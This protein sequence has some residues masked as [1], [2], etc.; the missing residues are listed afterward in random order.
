[1]PT[2]SRGSLSFLG[3]HA[4]TMIRLRRVALAACFLA[5]PFVF[6]ESGCASRGPDL[7]ARMASAK[8]IYE[9]VGYTAFGAPAMGTT[10]EGTDGKVPLPLKEGCYQIVTFPGDGLK[11]IE[12]SL[13]D[14]AGKP[15]GEVKKQEGSVSIKHCVTEAATYNLVVKSTGGSGSFVA[16][17]YASS[18]KSASKGPDEPAGPTDCTGDDC[19]EPMI[20]DGSGD[21]CSG[22]IELAAGASIKGNNGGKGFAQRASCA[23]AEGPS[24][25]YRIH[26]ENRHKL[27][28][29][30]SAKFDAV[31]G[32][33]RADHN[34]GYLCDAGREVDCSDDSEG[35]QTKSHIE[36]VVDTGDYGVVI[37]GYE[38]D[39]KGDFELKTRLEEAPS[40]EAVCGTARAASTGQKTTEF[41]NAEGS[42]FHPSCATTSGSEALFKFDLKSRSRVRL[43]MRSSSGGESSI[44]VRKRCEDPATEMV[45]SK[46]WHID[47]IAWT[48]LMDS[49]AYTVI[50][51]TTDA[52]HS[53]SVD[54]SLDRADAQGNGGIDGDTCKDAKPLQLGTQLTIDSFQAKAD[55]RASCAADGAA[56]LVYKL[57]VK[58]KSR[59]FVSTIEDE[60]H[61]VFA[62]QKSCGDT[63]GEIAC[64]IASTSK[65]FDATVDPGS[66]FFVI[67]GKG[68]DDFGRTKLSAKLRELAP[69]VA[70]CKAAPKL[71]PGTPINDTTAGSPDRFASEKCGGTVWSQTSGDK[72]YQ[73][74]LK[75]KSKVSLSLKGGTFYNAIMSLRSDC[76]DPTRNEIVCSNYYS[77]QIDRELDPGTYFVVVDG[78][79]TKAEGTFTLEMTSKPVK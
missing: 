25:V 31:M 28:L 22:G 75:E 61:H 68:V 6:A 32:L 35:L 38:A 9:S 37:T 10:A 30:L 17:P 1:M 63:K 74:T 79:G 15:V 65:G 57:D 59:L 72:V 48:G 7:A 58:A 19:P 24:A 53:A 56:D 70:A 66:Y 71:V 41:V 2:E 44:S 49:G 5:A 42:N 20:S 47:G 55:L 14:P 34:D 78:Y 43:G 23:A 50:A 13:L 46:D 21:P 3:Y 45:C 64:E 52:T 11:G 36:A 27:V 26:V 39:H 12:L 67:K 29:D 4:R 73:F 8:S 60:G 76:S 77:K 62:L 69:A 16:Q 40:L 54:L 18:E 51:S 33:Y